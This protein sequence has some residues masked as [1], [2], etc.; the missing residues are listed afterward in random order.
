MKSAKL[1]TSLGLSDNEAEVYL[2]LLEEGRLTVSGI[3]RESS[4]HR[5]A[6]YQILPTLEEKG[7][8]N[9][10]IVGKLLY[11]GAEPPERLRSLLSVINGELDIMIP[12]LS[13][14]Y[15]KDRP[16][17]RRLD[18]INGIHAVFDDIVRT[19]SKGD[20]YYQYCSVDEID[21]N[22]VGFTKAYDEAYEEGRFDQLIITDKE[23]LEARHPR[24]E[25]TIKVVPEEFVPFDHNISQYIYGNKVAFIDYN[26]PVSTVIENLELAELQRDV[27]KMLFRRL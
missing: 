13:A 27:F 22:R 10:R 19:L 16:V 8:I 2:T 15:G 25:V 11:Y 14:M 26:K 3:A 7:L 21:L 24:L 5:P 18:G 6:I 17:V 23:Y 4:L 20:E 1:L 9:K 12:Q